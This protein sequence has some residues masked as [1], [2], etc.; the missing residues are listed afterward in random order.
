V[1][2]FAL[3]FEKGT[4]IDNSQSTENKPAIIIKHN[5]ALI[6]FDVRDFS[7]INERKLS[8]IFHTLDLLNIKINLMQNSA[9][10]LSICIDNQ[11]WKIDSLVKKLSYDFDIH[12]NTDLTLISVKNYRSN[13]IEKVSKD[14]LI[15]LEQRTRDTFQIVVEP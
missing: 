7:F 11:G 8:L 14:K 12:Y 3:P 1:R 13:T 2:S 4:V 9:I 6:R 15:L 10:S 5:Q